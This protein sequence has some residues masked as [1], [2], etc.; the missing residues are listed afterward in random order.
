V[1]PKVETLDWDRIEYSGAGT[2]NP[3]EAPQFNPGFKRGFVMLDL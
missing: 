1:A 3:S 2:V